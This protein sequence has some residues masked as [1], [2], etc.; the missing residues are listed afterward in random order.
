MIAWPAP[1]RGP[2][3]VGP[4]AIVPGGQRERHLPAR[5]GRPVHVLVG[6]AVKGIHR[7]ARLNSA[8]GVP[9]R[10]EG[11]KRCSDRSTRAAWH[12]TVIDGPAPEL[13]PVLV[14]AETVIAK[15]QSEC[16][17]ARG[18]RRPVVAGVGVAVERIHRQPDFGCATGILD[19]HDGQQRGPNRGAGAAWHRAMVGRPAPE[20]SAIL[21]GAEAIR[22]QRQCECHL[23]RGVGCAV[24]AGVGRAI[25]S[26]H[27]QPGF[28][29]AVAISHGDDDRHRDGD[30][31]AGAA[32]N[33]AM[34][35]RPAPE[36]GPIF[37]RAEAIPDGVQRQGKRRSSFVIRRSGIV[38]VRRAAKGIHRQPDARRAVGIQHSDDDG[39]RDRDCCTRAAWDRTVI[40]CAAPELGAVLVS[41][42]TVIAQRQC[43][44]HLAGHIRRAVVIHVRRAAES[45]H[46]QANARRAI[47]ISHRDDDRHGHDDG[48][49]VAQRHCAVIRGPTPELGPVLVRAEA[50]H[51]RRQSKGRSSFVIRR[52]VV[53]QV[54]RAAKDVH[55]QAHLRHAVGILHRHPHWPRP[56]RL[57]DGFGYRHTVAHGVQLILKARKQDGIGDCRLLIADLNQSASR[58]IGIDGR[59]AIGQGGG[60]QPA[61]EIVGV[62]GHAAVPIY[63]RGQAI[64]RVVGVGDDLAVRVNRLR[65]VAVRV[66]AIADHARE[67]RGD[68]QRAI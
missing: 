9:H 1:E 16:V 22:S 2:I 64:R 28:R 61:G 5:A 18:A 40:R 12:R 47:R 36:R 13:R 46:R 27:W 59:D 44:R 34:V 29:R 8:V 60:D 57:R 38:H 67:R 20:L 63:D 33:R 43:E 49:L 10:D 11:Q 4:E 23:A 31:R 17:L 30:R 15:G 45:I 32:G 25:K 55:R 52:P 6:C 41:A 7:Q 56:G 62:P 53:A 50:I 68:R 26:I 37:V 58:V 66:V 35:A 24:V 51:A 14:R 21:V 65:A 19:G 42:E 3:L 48:G 39:H 54:G